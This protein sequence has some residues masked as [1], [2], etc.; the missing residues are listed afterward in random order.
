MTKMITLDEKPL[1]VSERHPVQAFIED[2]I[3]AR[4]KM[5]HAKFNKINPHYKSKYAD[6]GSVIDAVTG[7]LAEFGFTHFSR[8]NN[9]TLY[10]DIVHRLGE[11][12]TSEWTIKGAT[13]QERGKSITYG[14]RYLL[15]LMCGI[16]S[17]EDDD[18]EAN[19]RNGRSEPIDY[20]QC[21]WVKNTIAAIGV[22]GKPF[23]EQ[24][25]L[26]LIAKA[27]RIEDIL[28]SRYPAVK[29]ALEAKLRS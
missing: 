2:F 26:T 19:A 14:R 18:G 4:A 1:E 10:V 27:G 3:K 7:P 22:A 24:R 29:S 15:A 17:E 5:H 12:R 13:D 21:E 28:A 20:T 16:T 23:D 25:F 11:S 9:D 8:T 6:L